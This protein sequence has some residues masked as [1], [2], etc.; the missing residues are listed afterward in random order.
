ML[1]DYEL[2]VRCDVD[3]TLWSDRV[4]AA[5]AGIAVVDRDNG[6]MVVDAGTDTIIGAH[7]PW[8]DLLGT[9]LTD[10]AESLLLL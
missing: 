7:G 8:I 10:G 2:L 6:K 5:S 4:E 3:K 1:A 9:F